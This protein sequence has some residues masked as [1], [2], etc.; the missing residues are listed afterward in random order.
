MAISFIFTVCNGG[1]SCCNG[2]C[3]LGEGDCDS[4]SDCVGDLVCGSNNCPRSG[5][6]WD[7]GDDCCIKKGGMETEVLRILY[8]NCYVVC[9]GGDSCCN[10]QCG[11]GEG[12]CDRDSDCKGD[13]VCGSDNCPRTGLQ[14]DSGD[15]CCME[16]GGM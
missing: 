10:G 4:D 15:D 3:N 5:F 8:L 14:W 16:K 2:Q 6:E 12:D 9:Y 1:D 7:S 13:L 11:L